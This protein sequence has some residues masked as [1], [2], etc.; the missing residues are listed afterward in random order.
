MGYYINPQDMDKPEWLQLHG[1]RLPAAPTSFMTE[2]G[3]AVCLI[4][5]GGFFAAGIA[6]DQRELEAFARPDSRDQRDKR[7]YA[8]SRKDLEE[9]M[10]TIKTPVAWPETV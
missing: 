3:V 1:T 7:W 10:G 2:H 6:Y 9:V 4:D 8:V 5:N